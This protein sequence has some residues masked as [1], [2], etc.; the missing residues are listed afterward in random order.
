MALSSSQQ[1][2]MAVYS[3]KTM[4]IKPRSMRVRENDLK[5]I[6]EQIVDFD[7]VFLSAMFLLMMF[8]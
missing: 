3:G 4:K 2:L 8:D 6:I 7:E 1:E 5:V